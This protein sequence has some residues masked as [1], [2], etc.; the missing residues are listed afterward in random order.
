[1]QDRAKTRE[2]LIIELDALRERVAELEKNRVE[3]ALWE[4]EAQL[5]Q[6][7]DLVPHMIFVK[8]WDGKY[9]LVNKAVAEAYNTSVST[10]TG[11]YHADFHP[12]ES[13][14]Q[15][16][17]RD[18]R[19]VI[20]KG[21]PKFIPEQP[22]TD[23]QGN[24]RF[25]QTTKVPFHIL[26][27][28]TPAVLGV[29]IDIT[30]SKRAEEVLR[31]SE[32]KFRTL[33]ESAPDAIFIQKEG[34]FAYV[35]DAAI[36]LYGAA[37]EKELL[38]HRIVERVHS[39]YYAR[40]LERI[41]SINEEKKPSPVMEQKHVKLDGTTIDVEA[42]ASPI[43]YQ[44][45]QGALVFVR[46]ITERK[47]A[48]E[49]LLLSEDRYR[50][51]FEDAVLGIYRSTPEG[52]IINVN[53]AYAGMF[54]FDSPEEAKSFVNDVAVDLYVDPARRNE[55]VRMILDAKGPIHTENLYR[56]KDGSIFTGNLH[57][58]AVRDRQGK[59]LYL[60]GFVEDI[61]ERKR[62]EKALR[63][64]R[65]CLAATIESIPFEFWAMLPDGCYVMQNRIIRER[66]GDIIGKKPEDVSPNE[67]ILSVWQDNNRRAFAGELVKGEVRYVLG[68]EQRYFYNVVAPIYDAGR[69][70]GIV[71]INIDITDRKLLEAALTKV[72]E[73]LESQVAERTKELGAK[74]RRLEEFNA[75]LKV[76]LKLREE[77]RTELEET[78]LLN[79]K[80]L[81]V[82]YVEK[83][84]K[85]RLGGDQMTYLTILESH[86][87]EIAS[88]FTKRLSGKYPGLTPAEVQT[89]GLIRE[90]KTTKEIAELLCIS[91]NTVSS[92]RFH[93][94]KKLGLSNKKVNLRYY[95][96]SIE[97]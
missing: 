57:A 94:R 53:P 80:S 8:S 85:S 63:Q 82:P 11:K 71:G 89:V 34:R 47:Q 90:G 27:D 12:D 16:M 23:A 56:R 78:I 26:G 30:N 79:V 7:I 54:G 35:N 4:S 49:S 28:R 42:I 58:W 3:E 97:K 91:E 20:T 72:N 46:D 29:A 87:Q 77:D 41:R 76:L 15:N 18:D 2:Q 33:V 32:E 66:Y 21:E 60:E 81:I 69:T 83:L 45:S 44:Q 14:L 73:D 70:L 92:N 67:S 10:L 17:L 22:Y 5:R 75:A 62:A 48:E 59:F 36:R 13:E 37:S 74:T 51:L 64:S 50:R 19:E 43:R 40:I 84:K 52:E 65:A 93:I 25:L 88:P 55:I 38:G 6:I 68:N 61:T 96:K 9:L 31:E 86:I 95:L 24:L 1:M 39:V